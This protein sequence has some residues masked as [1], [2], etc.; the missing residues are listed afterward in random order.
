LGQNSDV[1]LDTMTVAVGNWETLT[2]SSSSATDDGAWEF[3]I[4]CDGTAGWVNVDD[5]SAS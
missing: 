3:V 1:V 4:D 2:A 5:W